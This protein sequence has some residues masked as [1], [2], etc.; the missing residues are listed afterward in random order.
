MGGAYEDN[1]GFWD[2][3]DPEELAFFDHVRRQS[4]RMVCK[5]CERIVCLM[6]PKI[7]CAPCASALE[8]GAP[9][10]MRDYSA[11]TPKRGV[12]E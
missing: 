6:S 11:A 4:V 5:R 2:L 3:D 1:F 9:I 12:R 10:S 8:C 7:F